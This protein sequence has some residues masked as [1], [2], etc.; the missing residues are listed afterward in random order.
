MDY[1]L[2]RRVPIYRML[3]NMDSKALLRCHH[4]L[5]V[6]KKRQSGI[7][8]EFSQQGEIAAGYLWLI[9]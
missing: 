2:A 1:I 6:D 3:A 7:A 9:E 8:V 5:L 4:P